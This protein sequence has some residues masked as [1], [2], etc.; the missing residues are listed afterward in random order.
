MATQRRLSGASKQRLKENLHFIQNGNG[1][2]ASEQLAPGQ[3]IRSQA[4]CHIGGEAGSDA[5]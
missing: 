2:V 3:I 5:S 4:W 1:N